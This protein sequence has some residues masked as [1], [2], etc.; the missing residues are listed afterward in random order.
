MV[1]TTRVRLRAASRRRRRARAAG[2]PDP[3]APYTS[4]GTFT[5]GALRAPGTPSIFRAAGPDAQPARPTLGFLRLPGAP[6]TTG[7]FATDVDFT[8]VRPPGVGDRLRRG[9][10]V[11]V[12]CVP[13]TT[14]VGA[15]AFVT[16]GYDVTDQHDEIV[17]S[18]RNT[19]F[20]Y[21]PDRGNGPNQEQ[22]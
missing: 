1:R 22:S 9:A 19:F 7:F 4:I 21:N 5:Q 14:R 10:I 8:F 17:A 3:I 2:Y 11:L 12:D 18:C 15:G 13:K 16:I 6:P 20:Y